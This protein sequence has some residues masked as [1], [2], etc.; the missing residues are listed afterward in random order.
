VAKPLASEQKDLWM[1]ALGQD[2]AASAGLLAGQFNLDHA[3][4]TAISAHAGIVGRDDV[5]KR[6]AALWS[7]AL[8][9]A[10]PALDQLAQA[11]TPR[12]GW[13]DIAL[14]ER[15]VA[16]MR[17]IAAQVRNRS[18]VYD[19]WRFRD[20]L[21][22]GLGI[23]VLFAGDSGTG[24]T[25]AAEALAHELGLLLYRIDL[26]GV[27]SKFIGET[28][29]NLRKLFDAAD[30]G[31]AILFFD[32][33]DA[34]FG[35]RSEVKDSHDRYANIEI[36]Y[37]LQRMESYRGLAILTTNM[38]SSLD[39]AFVRRLRFIVNFPFPGTPERL[40]IW[41]KVFP[42][43][44]DTS[45]LDFTRLARL[46]LTG[47]SIHNIALNA[48]FSA[49]AAGGGLTMPIL[50]EAARGEYAKLEK[51]INEADFRWLEQVGG[52]A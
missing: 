36:N 18:V 47:G 19:D 26:S 23:S 35:K 49:V 31:G 41:R 15:E 37:L 6:A 48:A 14:P 10:R 9:H 51:P 7:S 24:K 16:Q 22:R 27:V 38:K 20:R 17:Q 33:A 30:D 2:S 50:L 4:I 39:P 42:P 11:I 43:G 3:A 5:A 13:D 46:N 34:L 1:A 25:M 52:A 12:V 44:V 32:E 21:S 29:K 28:E 8:N 40:S 45:A